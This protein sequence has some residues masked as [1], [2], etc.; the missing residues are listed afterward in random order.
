MP[1]VRGRLGRHPARG[2][3]AARRHRRLGRSVSDDGFQLRGGD[4]RGV[5]EV[6]DERIAVSRLQAGD[7]VAGGEDG[8]RRGGGRVSRPSEPYDLGEV[9]GGRGAGG[10]EGRVRGDL[11]HDALDDPVQQGG[12]V[13]SED[14]L[15]PLQGVADRSRVLA[16]GWRSARVRRRAGRGG[17]A[18]EP[19]GRMGARRGRRSALRRGHGASALRRGGRGR[20]LGLSGADDRRRSRDRGSR[21]RVRAHRA[22]PWRGRLRGVRQARLGRPD[23]PQRAGGFVL[24]GAC[25]VLR[26]ARDLRP[27]G[28]GGQGERRRH[29]QAGRGGRAGG[30]RA[31]DA[32]LSAFLAVEGA[33]DLPQHAA[34]VRRDRPAARRRDGHLR[35]DDP[36]AGADLDR[37]AGDLDAEDRA[38]PALFDDRGAA[39][40]GA[41]AAAGLGRAADVFRQ[42]AGRG[43]GRDPARSGGERAHRRGFPGRGGRRL[44][45]G[46]RGGAVPRQRPR[47]G[48]VGEGD[49]HPRRLVRFR[50][51]PT[52]SRCA[53]GRTGSGRRASI[54]KAPTSIAAGSIPRCC[55]PAARWGGRPTRAC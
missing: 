40:L 13:Q 31:D 7:V 17:A 44:V 48:R 53:T 38:Q 34:M 46:G 11:D 9:S 33:G 22:E 32:F 39:G 36:R 20:V 43:Q 12:R 18:Q 8:A 45:R 37:R 19:G 16:C 50:G 6:R 55:N 49:G 27:Q 5:H 1:Q 41:V 4:R 15:W 54:S 52:P 10:A 14:F 23:D 3:Q 51:P 42:A 26:G 24:R 35:Q 25:A 2:V 30:A 29:R 47:P 21:N 28:Q